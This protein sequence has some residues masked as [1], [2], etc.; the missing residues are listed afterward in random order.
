MTIKRILCTQRRRRIPARFSWIDQRFV[1]DGHLER[2][3]ANAAAGAITATTSGL[4]LASA[5]AASALSA[6]G[7]EEAKSQ[8]SAGSAS[9]LRTSAS[10]ARA[11]VAATARA[12]GELG[13]ALRRPPVAVA[14]CSQKSRS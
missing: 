11:S 1:F 14:T 8:T 5:S 6:H 4:R 13:C 10:S 2:C 12:S 9:P 7:C 3:D